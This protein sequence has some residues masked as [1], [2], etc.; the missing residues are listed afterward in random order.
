MQVRPAEDTVDVRATVSVNPAIDPIDTVELPVTPAITET[1]VDAVIEKPGT[2]TVTVIVVVFVRL[3]EVP[4]TF[5]RYVPGAMLMLAETVTLTCPDPETVVVF[6][7]LVKPAGV[8]AVSP[9]EPVKP[10]TGET[11]RTVDDDV[12]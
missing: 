5:T 3:P 7:V 10:L 8:L 4:V 2:G 6:R 9:T 11:E 12:P 1:G